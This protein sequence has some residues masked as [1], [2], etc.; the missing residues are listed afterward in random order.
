MLAFVDRF[1]LSATVVLALASCGGGTTGTSPT[2]VKFLG[3][4][5][6]QDGAGISNTSM[7]VS[8]APSGEILV[9]SSTDGAGRFEM[10]LP[11]SE[12]SLD[13]SVEGTTPLSIRRAIPE[14]SAA[15]ASVEV[16]SSNKRSSLAAQVEARIVGSSC[17]EILFTPLSVD[18]TAVVEVPSVC[19]VQVEISTN[20]VNV[21]P[22][23]LVVSGQCAPGAAR[24]DFVVIETTGRETRSIDIAEALKSDCDALLIEVRSNGSDARALQFEVER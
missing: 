6:D 18:A 1:F 3:N 24:T 11:S 7:T 16:E 21:N 23:L 22:S 14:S 20:D 12:T 8:S 13:L 4:A 17:Q 2:V 15:F 10:T 9:A 19:E 5:Q